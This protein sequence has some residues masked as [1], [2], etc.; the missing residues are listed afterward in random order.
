MTGWLFAEGRFE[1][2]RGWLRDL[3]SESGW[4]LIPAIIGIRWFGL[5]GINVEAS[6]ERDPES[7]S[8]WAEPEIPRESPERGVPRIIFQTWKTRHDLPPR[9]A[10]WSRSFRKHHPE[11]QYVRWDDHD[12]RAFIARDFPWFLSQ[13]D[14]YPREIF[15]ADIIRLFFLFRYG[16]LYADL[17]TQSLRPMDN[18]V[19]GKDVVLG[20]IGNADSYDETYMNAIMASAPGQLFWLLAISIAIERFPGIARESGTPMP[21]YFTG[22]FVITEAA[23]FYLSN[24]VQKVQE[25][26]A[27]V[28]ARLPHPHSFSAGTL[29][30]LPCERWCPLNWL[31]SVHTLYRTEV[32]RRDHVI[33]EWW[34]RFQFRKSSLMTYW[35]HSWE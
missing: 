8:L 32:S 31:N 15:R 34:L 16:G 25:R 19:A 4:R 7:P 33:P 2:V 5:H 18:D 10:W 30:V 22:P 27:Q 11:W 14:A 17:D 35:A 13:Y 20:R 9:F 12:N 26:A 1:V 21:E 23:R 6:L 28:I 29:T 24:S 3:C